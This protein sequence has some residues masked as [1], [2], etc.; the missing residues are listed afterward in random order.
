MK[1]RKKEIKEIA[2]ADLGVDITPHLTI[3]SL[4]PPARRE[5]GKKVGTVAELIGLLHDEAKVI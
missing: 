5:A 2:A 1:A 4:E 3:N